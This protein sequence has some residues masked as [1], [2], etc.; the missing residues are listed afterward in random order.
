MRRLEKYYEKKDAGGN[1]NGEK[2]GVLMVV[3]QTVD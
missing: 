2:Q 3:L 1:K